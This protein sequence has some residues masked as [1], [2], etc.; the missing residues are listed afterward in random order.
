[1]FSN[2]ISSSNL[3]KRMFEDI[4]KL[5]FLSNESIFRKIFS[6]ALSKSVMID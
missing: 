5:I 6:V 4:P 2:F 3:L 1:M